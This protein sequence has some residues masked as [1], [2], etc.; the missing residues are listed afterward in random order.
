CARSGCQYYYFHNAYNSSNWNLYQASN[1]VSERTGA[2]AFTDTGPS[3]SLLGY[4]YPDASNPCIAQTI[5]PLTADKTTLHTAVNNLVAKTSTAGHI[6]S[7]WAWY[8]ISPN[9]A[10]LW[11]ADSQP[12]AYGTRDLL[13]VAV[14][15][16]DGLY[17]SPYCNGVIASDATSGSGQSFTHAN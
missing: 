17:N 13:K 4:S 6:G 14:L 10:N 7:A 9:F 1:C 3:T 8:M 12:A 5:V 11:P 16:T 2:D 15:M